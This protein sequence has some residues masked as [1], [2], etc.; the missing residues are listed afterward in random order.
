MPAADTAQRR[1]GLLLPFLLLVTAAA[2]AADSE[3]QSAVVLLYH[4]I[5][6]ST[7]RATSTSPA[8]FA[9]HLDMLAEQGYRVLPLDEIVRALDADGALPEKSVAITFD[10]GYESIYTAALPMLEARDWPFTV[11]VSTAAIDASYS[12]FMSWNQLRD[13][14]SRG[15]SVAN[16]SRSHD[17]LLRR[18]DGESEAAWQ[19]RVRDDILS[20]QSR[21][22][23]ELAGPQRLFA[24]P[25]GEFDTALAAIV[26]DLGY[27]GFGQQSGP[28]DARTDRSIL[29]RF[30]VATGYDDLDNLA[31]KLRTRPLPLQ[32]LAPASRV[33]GPRSPPPVLELRLAAGPYRRDELRCYVAGQPPASIVWNGDV[34]TVKAER[35]LGPGRSKYNCTAPSAEARGVFYWYSHLWIQPLDDGRWYAE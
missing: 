19:A 29:P 16:H 32:V 28:F 22:D 9:A 33:L 1:G 12:N 3:P 4:H 15:G 20:A 30:P 5:S 27:V 26:A 17:H 35:P 14:E 7:P 6:D 23:A 34:A 31:E 8:H 11:F 10:D 24:Y 21:L 25:Y 18:A 2:D 13:L